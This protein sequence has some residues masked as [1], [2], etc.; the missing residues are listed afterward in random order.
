MSGNGS[1]EDE[2]DG[3]CQAL[4]LELSEPPGEER[5]PGEAD[6]TVDRKEA[7]E[8]VETVECLREEEGTVREE[9]SEVWL[10]RE[11]VKGLTLG[12]D[13]LGGGLVG[14]LLK[15]SCEGA[16]VVLPASSEMV[17]VGVEGRV[18]EMAPGTRL[19][20]M[21]TAFR[22]GEEWREEGLNSGIVSCRR[23]E[24]RLETALLR[25]GG[26]AVACEVVRWT[27]LEWGSGVLREFVSRAELVVS[28]LSGLGLPLDLLL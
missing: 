7:V 17:I 27:D 11:V 3:R 24:V 5:V 22:R 26:L 8:M 15:G 20:I 2:E 16:L 23:V 18:W 9:E 14:G 6:R 25:S 12:V 28:P 13:G 1:S 21:T 10:E 4:Y 19:L